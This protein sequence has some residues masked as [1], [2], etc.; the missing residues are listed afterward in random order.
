MSLKPVEPPVAAEPAER[1]P[2]EELGAE[3]IIDEPGVKSWIETV[4]PGQRRPL[5]THRHP[6][7]TVVLSGAAGES[8]DARGELIKTS[9]VETGQV[10]FNRPDPNPMRHCMHNTSD[11]TLVMVAVELRSPDVEEEKR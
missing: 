4:P 8:R 11:R 6:W 2:W 1:E 3:L 9:A 5:H 10:L 7:V